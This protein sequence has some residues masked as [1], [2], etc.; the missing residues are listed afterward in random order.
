MPSPHFYFTEVDQIEDEWWITA[1]YFVGQ[2]SG[3]SPSGGL[4]SSQLWSQRGKTAGIYFKSH[5]PQKTI[6]SS[7]YHLHFFPFYLILKIHGP[8]QDVDVP[9]VVI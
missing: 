4:N 5:P 2:G 1:P 7:W 9:Y 3:A 8:K 6:I